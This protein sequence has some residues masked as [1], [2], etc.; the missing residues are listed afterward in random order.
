MSDPR[1][2]FHLAFPV[3]DLDR[4]R[5]FYIGLLGC[6]EGRSAETWVDL[7][8]FGHQLS[9]HRV[10]RDPTER[11]IQA[12]NPVD[13]ERVPLPHFGVVLD[14]GRWDELAAR[15]SGSGIV[16]DIAPTVRFEGEVGEQATMFFLDPFGNAL[17]IKGFEQAE[18]LFEH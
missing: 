6:K 16:F 12:R 17:E 11:P 8:F 15:L 4:A 18:G 10:E 9:L 3:D 5:E 2:P 14:R 13:G 7:D 1:P